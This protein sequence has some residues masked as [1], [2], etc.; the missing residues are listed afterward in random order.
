M[1]KVFLGLATIAAVLILCQWYVFVS[2]RNHLSKE[3]RRVTRGLAYSV[4]G[5]LGLGNFVALTL[6]FNSSWLPPD[7]FGQ[8]A[9]TVAFFNYLGLVLAMSLFFLILGVVSSVWSLKDYLAAAVGRIAARG[10]RPQPADERGCVGATAVGSVLEPENK[11][12]NQD[13]S[14]RVAENTPSCNSDLEEKRSTVDGAFTGPRT[15]RRVFLKWSTAAGLMTVVGYGAHG[16]AEAYDAPVVEEFDLAHPRLRDLVDPVTLIQITDLHFGLF[17]GTPEL[18]RLVEAVNALDGDALVITGDLF[19]SA[20]SPVDIATPILK[21]LR[22]R[23]LGNYAIMG[24]HDFYAGEWRSVA[25]IKESG[26]T[27]LRDQ[28][29]TFHDGEVPIHLGGIDDPLE[30]W[31]WGKRFP[32]LPAVMNKSPK[33]PGVKILLCHRPSILPLAS[34]AKVDLVLA[35]HT[36]GGQIILPAGGAERGLSVARIASPYTYGWYGHGLTRMYLNRGVGLTFVPWRI[37]CPPEIAV[38]HLHGT[39]SGDAFSIKSRS[40][41]IH[42]PRIKKV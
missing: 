24:N 16:I 2:C 9:V 31:V 22:P 30:N 38:L 28:W 1:D 5:I 6:S 35:G 19:H 14:F 39:D 33:S 4:L 23:R 8:K 29:V 41:K 32:N 26:I 37:N 42:E 13:G 27:L 3:P 36:H 34:R 11:D 25:T 10:P 15:T 12:S 40:W 18:K 21:K 7:S 17:M 20:I